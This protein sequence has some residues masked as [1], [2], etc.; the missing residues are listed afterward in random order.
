[1]VPNILRIALLSLKVLVSKHS[2]NQFWQSHNCC[3]RARPRQDRKVRHLTDPTT[4]EAVIRF[5]SQSITGLVPKSTMPQ[6]DNGRPQTSYHR[7]DHVFPVFP[8]TPIFIQCH[9]GKI[10]LSTI[11]GQFS[12][13]THLLVNSE[14]I[15][16]EVEFDGPREMNTNNSHRV[17]FLLLE[18]LTAAYAMPHIGSVKALHSK[19]QVNH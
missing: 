9:W 19:F 13:L 6:F 12:D 2:Y 7:H 17:S 4:Q 16:V 15:I 10:N 18:H 14:C 3:C 5:G 1:M 11:T 8:F